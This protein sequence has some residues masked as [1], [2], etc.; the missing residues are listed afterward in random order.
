MEYTILKVILVLCAYILSYGES[1]RTTD[2]LSVERLSFDLNYY[3]E[4][5]SVNESTWYTLRASKFPFGVC[6]DDSL[7]LTEKEKQ[8]FREAMQLWNIN[9]AIYR[10]KKFKTH[11]VV[12]IPRGKLFVES[13]DFDNF[14]IIDVGEDRLFYYAQLLSLFPIAPGGYFHNG[15]IRMSVEAGRWPKALFIN[16]AVHELGHALAI[17]HAPPGPD[18]PS[19]FMPPGDFGGCKEPYYNICE[20]TDY[21]FDIF[22]APFLN[23]R[24]I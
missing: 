7:F 14:N 23:E 8:W 11:S 1:I 12:N 4:D 19:N 15:M 3:R 9:F 5:Y 21:D 6:L 13:C 2:V 22:I 18:S 17:P 20:F 10:S 24:N 16:I